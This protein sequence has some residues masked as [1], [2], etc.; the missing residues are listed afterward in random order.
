LRNVWVAYA[1][2]RFYASQVKSFIGALVRQGLL[3][4][5]VGARLSARRQI[6][7]SR[8]KGTTILKGKFV[9]DGRRG[10][11]IPMG[12]VL[13]EDGRIRAVGSA[14]EIATAAP[15][16]V[17]DFPDA[18]LL[19]GLIDSH[20]H[21]SMDGSLDNYLDRMSDGVDVLMSRA[22]EMM[23]RA[24]VSGVTTCRCLG[25]REFLDVACKEAVAKENAA[26]PRLL[27]ATRGIRAPAGHGYMGY[28]FTGTEEIRRAIKENIDR[29]ADLT[30]IFITGTLRGGGNLPAYLTREEIKVA[31]DESHAAGRRVAAHCVGGDGLDWALECGLDTLEHAYQISP[32]QVTT[33][34]K[35]ATALVLTP[36]AVLSEDR[37][38]RLP[39]HLI[40]GHLDEKDQMCQAMKLTVQAGISY[41]VGTDGMH[42]D[43]G[44]EIAWL[45]TLGASNADALRAATIHGARICGIDDET[46]TLEPRKSADIIAVRGDPLADISALENV[47]AVMKGG[48]WIN[49]SAGR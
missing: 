15:A 6:K 19:P 23:T 49:K 47:I 28:P 1:S 7:G 48:Q 17:F 29:G 9:W 20:A 30:K 40:Q 8:L 25:D 5:A 43:L 44:R 18:T 31:I 11:S 36:G 10:S 24:L 26:G 46:G 21:L 45:C 35:S 22:A 12:A 33:L 42:G 13:I 41:A 14:A 16:E 39:R 4:S 2:G 27:I 32:A 38:R 3:V 34:A 37:V